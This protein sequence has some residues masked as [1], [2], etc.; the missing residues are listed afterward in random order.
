MG[1]ADPRLEGLR[2]YDELIAVHT[3]MRRGAD[4]T[5]AALWQL[6]VRGRADVITA[7][8]T[9]QWFVEFVNH[10]HDSEDELLWPV[11]REEFPRQ[12]VVLD[13]LSRQ[14][15][16]LEQ[17]LFSLGE[18]L[19][20]LAGVGRLIDG[21]RFDE[22]VIAALAD[23]EDLRISLAEHLAA[24]EPVLREMFPRI[25]DEDVRRIRA[26]IVASAP[27]RGS[28]LLLGLL[29]DPTPSVGHRALVSNLPITFRLLRPVLLLLYRHRI[30]RL[31][32]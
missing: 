4:L 1:K 12:V 14:H 13:S 25:A 5:V 17:A 18:R 26:A 10:H 32:V 19:R 7:L 24:E 30:R 20:M 23:A 3:V 16:K 8:S 29:R 31:G 15:E 22:A 2:M 28:S 11:L 21:S 27:R 9:G 6:S